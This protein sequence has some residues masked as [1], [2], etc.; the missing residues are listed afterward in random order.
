MMNVQRIFWKAF[1]FVTVALFVLA[2]VTT[3]T[4]AADLQRE[5]QVEA[6]T[7]QQAPVIRNHPAAQIPKA[8]NRK[9]FR[10]KWIGPNAQKPSEV[11]PTGQVPKAALPKDTPAPPILPKALTINEPVEDKSGQGEVLVPTY[12]KT[13]VAP[14][15]ETQVGWPSATTHKGWTSGHSDAG[16]WGEESMTG[17]PKQR[18]EESGPGDVQLPPVA[19]TAPAKKDNDD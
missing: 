3:S 11:S 13:T 4:P 5:V 1:L 16:S 12:P 17:F 18:E 9:M 19:H 8:P 2:F 15:G 6:P 10:L 7:I 14:A